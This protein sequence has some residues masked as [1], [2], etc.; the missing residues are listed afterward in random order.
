MAQDQKK[1]VTGG[2]TPKPPARPGGTSNQSAKDRSRAQSRPVSGKAPTGKSGKATGAGRPKP[3]ASGTGG[4]N[5]P[6]PGG[7]P[8]PV[9]AP[10]R[11]SGAMMAWAAVGLVIVVVAVLVVV[12]VATGNSAGKFTPT[13]S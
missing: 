11:F 12:K 1:T 7:R 5:K 4:G 13:L 9:A 8:A 3:G 6:R 2:N 10:R